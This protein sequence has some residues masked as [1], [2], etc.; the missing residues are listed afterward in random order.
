MNPYSVLYD[1]ITGKIPIT[2]IFWLILS[3]V[4]DLAGFFFYFQWQDKEYE[5]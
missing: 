1:F 2:F 3:L 5:Y 4:I